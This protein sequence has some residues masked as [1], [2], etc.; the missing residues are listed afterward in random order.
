MALVAILGLIAMFFAF[1]RL[2]RSKVR[3]NALSEAQTAAEVI[4]G[5]LSNHATEGELRQA[6]QAFSDERIAIDRSGYPSL[7]IAPSEPV[8]HGGV[9]RAVASFDGGHVQVVAPLEPTRTVALELT[10]LGAAVLG[11]MIGS[12]LAGGRMF[13]RG[14]TQPIQRMAV[15]ADQ[16]ASG[17]LTVRIGKVPSAE[18]DHLAGAFDGMTRRLE[19]ADQLQRRFIGDLAHEIATP[20]NAVGGFAIALADGTVR[21]EEQ[22]EAVE[23][24]GLETQRLFGLLDA[25]RQ[26]ERLDLAEPSPFQRFDVG[27]VVRAGSPHLHTAARAAAVNLHLGVR[28]TEGYGD[29]R[30]VSLILDNL[31]MNAIRYTAAG[32]RVDVT[33]R[34]EGD[35]VVLAV[36]DTGIG[37]AEEEQQRIFDRLYRVDVARTRATGG[38]GIGLS[39]VQRAALALKGH[40]ELES[41][42]GKGSEFRLV[43]PRFVEKGNAAGDQAD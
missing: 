17:D 1:D 32:G 42:L 39:L 9:A 40:V 18:L 25:L 28:A 35:S 38:F 7:H 5:L 13:S 15:A 27:R 24:I 21:P 10:G 33:V 26:L 37:I 12:A 2:E 8:G 14:V 6:A 29:P 4:T 30:L 16:V 19:E 23:L 20:L 34:P 3:R 43:F 11:I 41:R 22:A 36:R 31:V